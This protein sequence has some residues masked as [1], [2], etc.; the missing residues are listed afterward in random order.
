MPHLTITKASLSVHRI[1]KGVITCALS[2]LETVLNEGFLLVQKVGKL[3]LTVSSCE[4]ESAVWSMAVWSKTELPSL[5]HPSSTETSCYKWYDVKRGAGRDICVFIH[6]NQK[7]E[8]A[9]TNGLKWKLCT[10]SCEH[11]RMKQN[12]GMHAKKIIFKPLQ[13]GRNHF[14]I[15]KTT[16]KTEKINKI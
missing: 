5:L 12:V 10:K 6:T 9:D 1:F 3:W 16:L 2:V 8:R 7:I 14:R 11:V 15:I 13:W 4:W